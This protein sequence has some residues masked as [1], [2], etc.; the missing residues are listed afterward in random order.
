MKEKSRS[1]ESFLLLKDH[2]KYVRRLS[3]EDAGRLLLALFA[4][5][6]RKEVPDFYQED[7][8]SRLS[9]TYEIITD[10]MD[11]NEQRYSEIVEKR[12]IAGRKGGIK[13]GESRSKRSNCLNDEANEPDTDTDTGTV[14]DT[15]SD[16][17][18]ERDTTTEVPSDSVCSDSHGSALKADPANRPALFTYSQLLKKRD[19]GKV[20]LTDEGIRVFL[21]DMKAD[22]WTMYGKSVEK[23]LILRVLREWSNK[24]PEYWPDVSEVP[25]MPPIDEPAEK[26]AEKSEE[27]STEEQLKKY[28][29]AKW[30]DNLC[31]RAYTIQGTYNY[32]SNNSW[33]HQAMMTLI[34]AGY[35][36][37]DIENCVVWTAEAAKREMRKN[38]SSEPCS[39][40]WILESSR[41]EKFFENYKRGTSAE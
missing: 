34:D 19:A 21:E 41:F 8:S 29:S 13:S 33:E 36:M 27:I 39:P 26:V 3:L 22:D 30:C 7:D 31:N 4:Y 25:E 16:T 11:V 1:H 38:H 9:L 23:H 32:N 5:A 18:S 40:S 10:H 20:K 12:R 14:S 2:E 28:P 37:S 17:G 15:E 6:D 24:H 35:T